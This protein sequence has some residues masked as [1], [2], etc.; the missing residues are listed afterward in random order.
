MPASVDVWLTEAWDI[1]DRFDASCVV[2]LGEDMIDQ[3][4]LSERVHDPWN[5]VSCEA[6]RCWVIDL[7]GGVCKGPIEYTSS[8][9]AT[10][11]IKDVDRCICFNKGTVAA[12]AGCRI[13][14]R[15]VV[16]IGAGLVG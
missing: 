14:D 15:T 12:K 10:G 11:K 8:T 13:K 3:A 1:L 6:V 5:E 4:L 9:K 16:N 7:E 2:R